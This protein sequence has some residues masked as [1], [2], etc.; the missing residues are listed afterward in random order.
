MFL[1]ISKVTLALII[2]C[3][4]LYSTV[5]QNF[6]VMPYV[7][8]CLSVFSLVLGLIELQGMRKGFIGYI[9]MILSLCIMFT[10]IK[11]FLIH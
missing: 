8:L 9:F 7:M 6:D 3:L 5:T 11:G 10:S 1:K 4:A 2:I